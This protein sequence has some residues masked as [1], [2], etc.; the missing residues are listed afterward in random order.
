MRRIL[1][2]YGNNLQ[3]EQKK[4]LDNYI[5]VPI[6]D[7]QN[8]LD[9]YLDL[10]MKEIL[11]KFQIAQQLKEIFLKQMSNMNSMVNFKKY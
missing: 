2:N 10:Y 5:K 4:Y 3:V 8:Q 11:R 1:A 9:K 7:L 6:T